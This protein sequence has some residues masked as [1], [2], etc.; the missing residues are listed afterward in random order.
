MAHKHKQQHV[1]AAETILPRRA[2]L[3]SAAHGKI[4]RKSTKIAKIDIK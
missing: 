1:A 3:S 4:N 2:T